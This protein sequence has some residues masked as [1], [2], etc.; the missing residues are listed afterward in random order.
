MFSGTST[1]T[2]SILS[3]LFSLAK[4]FI[5]HVCV[6]VDQG[7]VVVTFTT[8]P[9][10]IVFSVFQSADTMRISSSFKYAVATGTRFHHAALCITVYVS[11]SFHGVNVNEATLLS[12]DHVNG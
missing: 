9:R 12:F 8:S 5:V 1:Q 11:D 10:A 7:N 3:L 6:S 2:L 4:N